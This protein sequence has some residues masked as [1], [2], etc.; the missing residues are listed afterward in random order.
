MPEK[1]KEKVFDTLKSL[2]HDQTDKF[3]ASEIAG[4][5]GLSRQVTSH[6]LTQL[7]RSGAVMKTGTRPVFWS[8]A[9]E[10]HDQNP[11]KIPG[12]LA[13]ADPFHL[14]IGY[15]GSQKDAVEQCRATVNYPPNGL[16]LNY[17]W[18]ERC[19]EEL[20]C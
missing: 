5:L 13:N 16:P 19:R 8:L 18:E 11:D 17:Q 7:L 2:I 10:H 14:F 1:A 20:S 12:D 4:K 15:D 3:T 9:A 6:Y